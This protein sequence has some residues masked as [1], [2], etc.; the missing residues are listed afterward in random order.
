VRRH[1]SS[2]RKVSKTRDVALQRRWMIGRRSPAFGDHSTDQDLFLTELKKGGA[3]LL[4][5][6]DM[7]HGAYRPA[8]PAGRDQSVFI[9][10]RS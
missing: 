10:S 5:R 1:L 9:A 2:R 6:N 7:L 3:A 4:H 8:R